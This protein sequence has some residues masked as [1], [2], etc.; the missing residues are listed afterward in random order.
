MQ[1]NVN[2]LACRHLGSKHAKLTKD[3]VHP[4][5]REFQENGSRYIFIVLHFQD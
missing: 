2:A 4:D 1:A 5:Q 3:I